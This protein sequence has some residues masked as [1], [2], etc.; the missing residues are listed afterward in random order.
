MELGGSMPKAGLFG[1]RLGVDAA[2]SYR[3]RGD[4][5]RTPR[6]E[7]HKA[8]GLRIVGG[9]GPREPACV[10][11]GEAKPVS[12]PAAI[13]VASPPGSRGEGQTSRGEKEV[14]KQVACHRRTSG[15]DQADP[16][17]AVAVLA[18]TAPMTVCCVRL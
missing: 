13:S 18:R 9:G 16:R 17:E 11:E 7:S 5:G 3:W 12:V 2:C 4:L 15:A 1:V 6:E 14:G 8:S 10:F